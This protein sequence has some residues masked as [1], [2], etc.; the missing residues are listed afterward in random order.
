M[1]LQASE[2]QNVFRVYIKTSHSLHRVQCKCIVVHQNNNIYKKCI[3][4]L[5]TVVCPWVFFL[6]VFSVKNK[7][8][9]QEKEF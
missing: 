8:D 7:H 5:N 6:I 4:G 3:I 9:V 2:I 1:R